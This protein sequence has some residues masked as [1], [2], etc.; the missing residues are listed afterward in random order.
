MSGFICS[1]SASYPHSLI[2]CNNPISAFEYLHPSLAG[3]EVPALPGA[4]I[5][6]GLLPKGSSGTTSAGGRATTGIVD[7][8]QIFTPLYN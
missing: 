4:V 5:C 6:F 8:P 3:S 7:F 1:I 2:A